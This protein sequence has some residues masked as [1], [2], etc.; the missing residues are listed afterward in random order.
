MPFQIIE[1]TLVSALATDGTLSLSYPSGYQAGH[2]KLGAR[3]TLMVDDNDA[4]DSPNDFTLTFGDSAITLTWKAT[5]TLPIGS[6]LA[7]QL[8]QPGEALVFVK[9]KK[10]NAE[11]VVEKK[12]LNINFGT[13]IAS[14]DDCFI[15]AATGTELPNAETVSYDF[16]ATAASP[17]DGVSNDGLIDEKIGRNIIVTA[18]HLS[19]KV[20]MTVLVT[21]LDVWGDELTESFAVAAG[22][23]SEV[24]TG[25]KAFASVTTIDFVASGNAEAN[26]ISVGFGSTL[27]LPIYL[28]TDAYVLREIV[29]GA[30]ATNGV[31]VAG[32]GNTTPT[33]T[34]GDV[35]GTYTPNSAPDGGTEYEIDVAL[36]DPGFVGPDQA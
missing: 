15:K 1:D 2:F 33:A 36:S 31:V 29:D 10:R 8:D 9:D 5:P 27:G 34:T 24:V 30:V 25:K 32:K 22:G 11:C 18:S 13:P 16:P 14:D 26:T 19:A 20:A 3:H 28:P 23:T 35:R 7:I 12:I 6:V 21:G 17:Q 4:Y